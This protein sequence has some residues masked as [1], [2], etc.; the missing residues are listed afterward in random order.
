MPVATPEQYA[1]MLDAAQANNY[2][3]P[4]INIGSTETANAALKGFADSG[5]DGGA[6]KHR[7]YE[8]EYIP[9]FR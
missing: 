5:S 2:A 9:D 4:A 6:Q 3:Y 1:K 7:F 8:F